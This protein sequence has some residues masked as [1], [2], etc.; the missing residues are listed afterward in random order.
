LS[1]RPEHTPRERGFRLVPINESGAPIEP[2][3][4]ADPVVFEV[5]QATAALYQ[6][7]GFVPPWIGYL[8]IDGDTCIGSCGFNGPAADGVAEIAYF[9]FPGHEGRGVA[10][11]MAQALLWVTRN[12]GT[13]RPTVIAHT[14]PEENASTAILRK[15]GLQCQGEV[16]DDENN[17]VWRWHEPR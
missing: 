3:H 1:P 13:E 9:T 6:R 8:A 17:Q 16:I 10:T 7:K 5:M 15:L 14:L 4:A 2:L 12:V 11:R